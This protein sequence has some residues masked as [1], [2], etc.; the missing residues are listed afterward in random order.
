VNFRELLAVRGVAR[1]SLP[2]LPAITGRRPLLE[3]RLWAVAAPARLRTSAGAGAPASAASW[4][5]AGAAV[6][7]L[8][9]TAVAVAWFTVRRWRAARSG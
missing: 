9:G 8:L 5:A 6:A 3:P 2:A 4:A 1:P 7:G